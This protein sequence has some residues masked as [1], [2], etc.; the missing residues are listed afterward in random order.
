MIRKRTIGLLVFFLILGVFAIYFLF[1]RMIVHKERYLTAS[2][3]DKAFVQLMDTLIADGVFKMNEGEIILDEKTLRDKNIGK[4]TEER[5][6]NHL[7]FLYTRNGKIYFDKQS[8]SIVNSRAFAEERILRGSFLDRNGVVLARSDVDEKTWKQKRQYPYGPEFYHLIGHWNLTFGKRNLEKELDDYLNGKLHSPVYRKT[9]DPFKQLQLGDDVILTIDSKIQRLAY[10]LMY[11]KKSAVV[12]LDVRTGEI[13]AAVSAPS[14][15]PNTEE[16]N[17]WREAF[18]DEERPYENRAFSVPYPPGSTFKTIVASAWLESENSET[19]YRTICTGKKNK[20][21]ISDIH[22]HGREDI[23]KAYADS[24]NVFF[25][26]IGVLLGK[27]LLDYS[28]RFGFNK[29]INLVPQIRDHSYKAEKSIV[30]SWN[31]FRKG[32]NEVK[33]FSS[34]DFKRNPRLVAQGSI[35]QNLTTATPLQMAMVAATIANKGVLLNP[36]IIKEIRTG[37]GKKILF[38]AKPIEIGRAAKAKTAL[39]I[40]RLMEAV[41]L[42]G[43]GKD[44]KK[45]YLEDGKC[46]TSPKNKYDKSLRIAGKTGTAEVGDKNGNGKIDLD[47]KPHSWFIGFAPADNPKVAIAVIAENQGFGSL[48][49]AP[50]AADI[51]AEACNSKVI[52][53][54]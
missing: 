49:A 44:V 32:K 5:I 46:T 50:I 52:M 2:Y 41:M 6:R 30:F 18:M 23:A 36:Y 17:M 33:V 27:D 15:D 28:E 54:Y 19:E 14:F 26:E 45:I 35:G 9:S 38:F 42:T 40:R 10:S 13:L 47:E 1:D 53:S 29:D 20:Y 24:C 11:G 4:K 43:T 12:V 48:T 7:A 16:R 3:T 39:E 51:L 31:D 25:S 34:I 22:V 8:V 37:D 21:G